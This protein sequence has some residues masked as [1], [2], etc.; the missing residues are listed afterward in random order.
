MYFVLIIFTQT[1]FSLFLCLFFVS[2]SFCLKGRAFV[3]AELVCS[4]RTRRLVLF[5]L[6]SSF[7]PCYSPESGLPA[8]ILEGEVSPF[9]RS[10]ALK[11]VEPSALSPSFYIN[12]PSLKIPLSDLEKTPRVSDRH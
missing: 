9:M 7:G 11:P 3:R 10:S 6:S 2:V 8:D 12:N 5:L 4:Y 1:Y